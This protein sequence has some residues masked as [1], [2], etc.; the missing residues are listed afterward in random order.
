MHKMDAL[1][2]PCASCVAGA[3]AS[4]AC[5]VLRHAFILI[6]YLTVIKYIYLSTCVYNSTNFRMNVYSLFVMIINYSRCSNVL[7]QVGT[8]IY[9]LINLISQFCN[10]QTYVLVLSCT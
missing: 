8:F 3:D 7:Y 5:C 6:L 2:N 9:L 1:G 4:N 10:F